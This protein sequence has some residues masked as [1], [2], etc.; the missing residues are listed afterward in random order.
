MTKLTRAERKTRKKHESVKKLS[1]FSHAIKFAISPS[2]ILAFSN[3]ACP[4]QARNTAAQWALMKSRPSKNKT[5]MK[6]NNNQLCVTLN[7]ILVR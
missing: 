6:I 5:S 1:I 2:P 4:F 3:T 7:S